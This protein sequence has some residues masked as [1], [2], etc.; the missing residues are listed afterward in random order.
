M[1]YP[2]GN[3]HRK[4]QPYEPPATAEDDIATDKDSQFRPAPVG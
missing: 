1:P 4:H 2:P 3:E